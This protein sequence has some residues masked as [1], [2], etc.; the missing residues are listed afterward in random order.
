MQYYK[1]SLL[2]RIG[3]ISSRN[4]EEESFS[5]NNSLVIKLNKDKMIVSS[6]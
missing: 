4:L 5:I 2:L 3:E 1:T 6:F